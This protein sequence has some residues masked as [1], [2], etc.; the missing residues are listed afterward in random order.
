MKAPIWIE[1]PMI[2]CS[3][4]F[5]LENNS[6]K[7]T[8]TMASIGKGKAHKHLPN[9]NV[10]KWSDEQVLIVLSILHTYNMVDLIEAATVSELIPHEIIINSLSTPH[11][12]SHICRFQI[13]FLWNPALFIQLIE[14]FN[15]HFTLNEYICVC[16]ICKLCAPAKPMNIEQASI[17]LH[18]RMWIIIWSMY[19]QTKRNDNHFM[20]NSIEL[21]V[22]D[23]RDHQM[24]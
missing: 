6:S 17:V 8:H 2:F 24:E 11:W 7:L 23:L 3:F 12:F 13:H 14:S 5:S 10:Y 4:P 15:W 18:L 20:N 21:S 1:S 9:R 16:R 19:G 22:F